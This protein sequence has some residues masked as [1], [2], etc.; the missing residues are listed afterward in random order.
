MVKLVDSFLS[1]PVYEEMLSARNIVTRTLSDAHTHA[2]WAQLQFARNDLSC[3][4]Y[5]RLPPVKG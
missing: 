5:T 3:V 4:V 1:V 2:G